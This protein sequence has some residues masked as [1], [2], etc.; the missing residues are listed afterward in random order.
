MPLVGYGTWPLRSEAATR[1]VAHALETGYRLVDTAENYDNER[2]VGAGLRASGLPRDEYFVTTKFNRRWHG[3]DLV[4]T[5]LDR[6]IDQLGLEYLDMLM[7][8]WPNPAQ[9]RYVAAWRGLVRLLEEK[10]VRAIATSNFK[11]AH[12]G[13][14]LD[15]TGIAPDVN[16]IQLSPAFPRIADRTIAGE[17]GT[18]IQSWSPLGGED[19]SLRRDPLISD[20]ARRH[21]RTPAQV[22]LRWHL[23]SGLA[24]VVKSADPERMRDNLRVFDFALTPDDLT[25]MEALRRP[26]HEAVDSDAFGH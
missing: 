8:H 14:L 1:A 16:Q 11:P 7:I 17:L 9:D 5:A 4:G 18:V 25:A 13:R 24:V 20:I 12:L 22:V 10:R 21:G 23:Q 2:A 15:E 3:E 6:G 26:D 19:T